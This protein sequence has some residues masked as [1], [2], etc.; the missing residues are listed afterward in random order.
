MSLKLYTYPNNPRAWKALIAAKYAGVNIEVPSFDFPKDLQTNEFRS[1]NPLAKVPVLE[2]PEGCIFESNAI[3]RYVGRKS[4]NLY[5]TNDY[6]ASLVDQ[7][8]D[9]SVNELELPLNVWTFPILG[10]MEF[11]HEATEKAKQDV[12]KALNILNQHFLAH[13]YL[14]GESITIADIALAMSLYRGYKLVFDPKFRKGFQNVNRWFNTVIRQPNWAGV[15]GSFQYA[16]TM[17]VAK[18]TE[19]KAEP[20][21]EVAK[22]D[23]EPAPAPAK[24]PNPLDLLPPSK[25]NLEEWKRYYSNAKDTRGDA[26]KWFWEHLDEGYS[27][28]FCDYKYNDELDSQQFRVSNLLGGYIQRLDRL[29]KYGFASL[30]IFGE[31]PNFEIGGCFLVRGQEIPFEL[32]D[33]DDTE[34]YNF[35]KADITSEADRTLVEDYFSWEGNFAGREKKFLDGK[36]FK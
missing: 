22:D 11:N 30:I 4:S 2:T 14:V 28:W 10:W 21:K 27:L 19:K 26:M 20:K 34:L 5:G 32:S 24:K 36:I 8:I 31:Q 13:T 29:R 33:V 17:A 18:P 15:I 7:W 6:T 16:E 3:L 25:L 12:Q 9:F 35:R 1:K 23:E